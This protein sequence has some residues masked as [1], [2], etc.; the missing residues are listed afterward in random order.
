MADILHCIKVFLSGISLLVVLQVND[1][2]CELAGTV[3]ASSGNPKQMPDK[4]LLFDAY[5]PNW[6]L[7]WRGGVRF[8]EGQNAT[9]E[10][11]NLRKQM[12]LSRGLTALTSWAY[13]VFLPVCVDM[14]M[15]A[16]PFSF[17]MTLEVI[18]FPLSRN[19]TGLISMYL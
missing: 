15:T 3:V 12:V 1:N 17:N 2:S 6:C 14:R 19:V 16:L 4:E 5:L 11:V 8:P 10:E 18:L 13:H 7:I 9:Q